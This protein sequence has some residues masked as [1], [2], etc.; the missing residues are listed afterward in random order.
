MLKII[1]LYES[2][3]H[4][5]TSTLNILISLLQLA[6]GQEV[7]QCLL[8]KDR[9]VSL[10][11]RDLIIGIATGGDNKTEVRKNCVFFE[12]NNCDIVFTAT[13]KKKDSGSVQALKIFAETKY[14]KVK[15]HRKNIAK[16]DKTFNEVNFRQASDLFNIYLN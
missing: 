16:D 8:N 4:G 5:K 2:A 1:A 10:K 14:L 6:N 15:R 3:N 7:E 13:R 11:Y 12:D 9:R